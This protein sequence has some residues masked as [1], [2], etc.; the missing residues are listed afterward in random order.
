MFRSFFKYLLIFLSITFINKE[1]KAI[2]G[3]DISNKISEWLLLEGISGDPVFSKKSVYK[4]C[5]SEL[6]ITRAF[7]DYKTIK[8]SCLDIDGF[9]L[10]VRIKSKIIK[11]KNYKNVVFKKKALL[12]N[13]KPK[14]TRE[15]VTI[16]LKRALEKI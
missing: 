7:K 5:S 6:Q 16:K 8:L 2:N 12:S 11:H 4:D 13:L 3:K 15:Y 14:K 1:T 9:K 10:F